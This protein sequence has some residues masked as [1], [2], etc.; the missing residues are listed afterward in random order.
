EKSTTKRCAIATGRIILQKKT[1]DAIKNSKIKKGNVLATATVAAIMAVKKTQELIPMCHQIPITSIDV[2]FKF[3]TTD[4]AITVQV[5]VK[6][7]SR[8]GVEMEALTG[9]S[10]ALLTIWD[11][12]KSAEKDSSGNYPDTIISSIRVIKKV[13]I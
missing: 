6:S 4:N 3:E 2:D 11:M 5:E 7:L 8:T 12:V 13:K 10:V 9:V 1:I